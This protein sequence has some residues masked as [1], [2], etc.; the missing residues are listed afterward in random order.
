MSRWSATHP[1][2]AGINHRINA[3]D[4]RLKSDVARGSVTPDRAAQ[5]EQSGQTIRGGARAMAYSNG[6]GGHL[7]KD[8]AQIVRQQLTQRDEDLYEAEHAP[9][10]DSGR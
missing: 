3:Q 10:Y 4:A 6:N 1:V 5:L 7:N 9:S 2:R 8:Q